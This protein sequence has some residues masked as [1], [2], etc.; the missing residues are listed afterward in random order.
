V[1]R[2]SGCATRSHPNLHYEI[3]NRIALGAYIIDLERVT[4]YSPGGPDV[5]YA[6]LVYR[7]DARLNREILILCRITS[8]RVCE[9]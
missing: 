6:I 8:Q 2:L 3:R 5:L 7:F 1:P 9:K 4:G